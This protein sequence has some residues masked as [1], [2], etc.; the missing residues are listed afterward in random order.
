MRNVKLAVPFSVD[1]KAPYVFQMDIA[2]VASYNFP[3]K[4][5][6]RRSSSANSFI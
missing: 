5:D 4:Y 6:I 3:S 2:T 1:W